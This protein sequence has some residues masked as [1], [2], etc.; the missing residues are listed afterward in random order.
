MV[1]QHF[2]QAMT[3]DLWSSSLRVESWTAVS[4]EINQEAYEVYRVRS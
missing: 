2:Y 1:G 4:R 3:N